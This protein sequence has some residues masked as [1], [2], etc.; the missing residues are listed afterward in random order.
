M[1]PAPMS[2]TSGVGSRVMGHFP[3]GGTYLGLDGT[4]WGAES[5]KQSKECDGVRIAEFRVS[6]NSRSEKC[7]NI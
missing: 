7:H 6:P 4:K 1:I 3:C 5:V 2:H